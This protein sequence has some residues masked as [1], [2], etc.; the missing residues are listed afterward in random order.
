MRNWIQ[1]WHNSGVGLPNAEKF[2][3]HWFVDAA[4][5]AYGDVVYLRIIYEDNIVIT[6]LQGKKI[7]PIKPLLTIPR[8]ELTAA[9]LLAKLAN[10]LSAAIDIKYISVHLW[11]D[12]TDVLFWLKY[13]PSRW[14]VF[15]ANRCSKI[16]TLVPN[17]CWRHVRSGYNLADCLS[18]CKSPSDLGGYRLWWQGPVWLGE[19]TTSFETNTNENDDHVRPTTSSSTATISSYYS[20]GFG[21]EVFYPS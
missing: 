4:K 14:P 8:L 16:H 11:S 17:A 2:E 21:K 3:L 13:H 9:V 5:L 1:S 19:E 18:R 20:L 10:K 15:I 7:S 6:V 12:S